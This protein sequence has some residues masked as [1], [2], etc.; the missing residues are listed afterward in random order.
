MIFQDSATAV[1]RHGRRTLIEESNNSKD[2]ATSVFKE[3]FDVASGHQKI[4][5]SVKNYFTAAF[6][7]PASSCSNNPPI[8]LVIRKYRVMKAK[9]VT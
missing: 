7:K 8:H 5:S 9:I 3:D 6:G 4:F 1:W 2:E